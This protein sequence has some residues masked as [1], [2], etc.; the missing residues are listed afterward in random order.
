MACIK[1]DKDPEG[2][3]DLEELIHLTF[4]ESTGI[5][6]VYDTI[7]SDTSI[8]YTQPLSLYKVN[9]WSEEHPKM[10][11]IGDYWDEKTMTEIQALLQEYEDLFPK[12]F[13]ELKGIKG[14][15]GEMRIELKPDAK[16]VKHRLY[17]L[18]PQVKEKDKK[19]IDRM[20][21][22]ELIFLMDEVE[23]ISPIVI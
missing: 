5:R 18:N 8:S 15:L 1:V 10:E 7:S 4:Q 6:E 13:L 9:I 3:K 11:S 14:E 20:L 21:E 16:P 23:W 2:T 19:G 12:S 22:S 17:R